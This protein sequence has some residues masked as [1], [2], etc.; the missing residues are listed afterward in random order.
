[1]KTNF[2]YLGALLV[3]LSSCKKT[4]TKTEE[5]VV[6]KDTVAVETKAIPMD[7]VAMQKAWNEYMT[8]GEA[9]KRLAADNGMWNDEITTWMAPDAKPMMNK[10]VAD[11]KMILGGRYQQS[12]HTGNFMGMPFEGIST[13][14]FDNASQ[15]YTST[16]IDNMGTGI[17]VMKG[18][19]NETSK[20][21]EFKGEMT[22]PMTKKV[23]PTRE[24]VS[25][26]DENTQK[27]EMFDVTPEGKEY[28]SMEIKMTRKK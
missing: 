27:M 1:M 6:K 26:I 8:P 24:V 11:V 4:E 10:S 17:M 13:V 2:I 16:W 21:I 22:D 7:S 3:M 28:K 12:R 18:K 25:F 15:E 5:T 20:S 19:Y 14:A 23:K 9:H